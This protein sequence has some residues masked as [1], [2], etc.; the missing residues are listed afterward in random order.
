MEPRHER[1][2]EYRQLAVDHELARAKPTDGP[3][4]VREAPGM[5][6]AGPAQEAHAH[7]V[8]VGDD[9]PAV[10]LL[11]VD[12]AVAVERLGASWGC[13]ALARSEAA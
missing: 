13:I 1:F 7:A 4:D 9:P 3:R 2:I 5:V 6:A 12:P 11:L 10:D 8:L